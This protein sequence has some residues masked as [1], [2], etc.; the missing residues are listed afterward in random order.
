MQ[1]SLRRTL[2]LGVILLLAWNTTLGAQ[3]R[4]S[5]D[6][7]RW[8]DQ[9]CPRSLGPSLWRSCIDRERAALT[10]ADP[11]KLSSLPASSQQWVANSCP[12][13]LGPSLYASCVQREVEALQ[14]PGWPSMSHLSASDQQWVTQSC[15][16]SLGPSLW[17][18]CAAREIA[19]ISPQRQIEPSIRTSPPLATPRPSPPPKIARPA[20]SW[21]KWEGKRPPMPARLGSQ[22]LSPQQV[23]QLV[24]PSVYLVI[25]GDT[26]E[27][28]T[29]GNA[30]LGSAVS[31]SEDTALT[32]CHIVEGKNIIL[33]KGEKEQSSMRA[34]LIYA[35]PSSDRCILRVRG[36]L[37]SVVGVRSAS[38]LAIGERVYTIGNPS[39]LTKTLGEGIISGLRQ[40]NDI[41][42][43]QTTAQISRGSSGGALVDAK[44]ALVGITTI[45]LRDAQSLNFA[46]AADEYWR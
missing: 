14:K 1:H 20:T 15:P 30:H 22:E 4:I 6:Q 44:G 21:P 16:P 42:Y 45:L 8:L 5:G 39:G 12:K 24:A 18:S 26:P 25:A 7:Q 23:Y 11:S 43:V 31:V 2:V 34:T 40:R 41:A 17:R 38:D 19:A 36:T 46:I 29:S 28:I 10:R 35:H 13:S 3:G 33:L 27:A 32:N 9:T 37:R